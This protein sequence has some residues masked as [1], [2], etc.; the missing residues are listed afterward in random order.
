MGSRQDIVDFIVEHA[1]AAGDVS[2][3][4]M[5][6]EYGVYAR[7]KFVALVCD[8]RLFMKPTDAGIALLGQPEFA[9]PYPGAK[10]HPVVD[11]DR[12]D[13]APFLA[14]LFTVTADAMPATK[15]K[16]KKAKS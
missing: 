6:G 13:D 16:K 5:F 8:D 9:A 7:G 15:P 3:R 2:A 12:W 11:E 4:K 10:D 14:E 1:S